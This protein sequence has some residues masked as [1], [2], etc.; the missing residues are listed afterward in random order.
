[1]Q[2]LLDERINVCFDDLKQ[3]ITSALRHGLMLNF[4]AKAD[5]MQSD[6]IIAEIKNAK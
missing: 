3:A 1:V 4:Q 6:Q 5:S 2:A